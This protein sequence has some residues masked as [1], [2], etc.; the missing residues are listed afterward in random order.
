M[1]DEWHGRLNGSLVDCL[2]DGGHAMLNHP[3]DHEKRT[4]DAT[5]QHLGISR[6]CI[7]Q[8]PLQGAT[9][10]QNVRRDWTTLL[11]LCQPLFEHHLEEAG[12]A[13]GDP[14]INSWED[15]HET[16]VSM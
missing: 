13:M 6:V 15:L 10:L 4:H 12:N 9:E 5:A 8:S 11:E 1:D 16:V 3:S 14:W 7:C 2:V